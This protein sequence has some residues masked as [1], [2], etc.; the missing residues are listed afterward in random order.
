[1]RDLDV[2]A[3]K[4]HTCAEAYLPAH[5]KDIPSI[6]KGLVFSE[7]LLHSVAIDLLYDEATGHVTLLV[8]DTSSSAHEA[9]IQS[10]CAINMAAA[11]FGCSVF[12]AKPNSTEGPPCTI[13]TT[14][15]GIFQK[16]WAC[17]QQLIGG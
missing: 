6:R 12:I 8:Q 17:Q 9:C 10:W 1:M 3:D 7:S 5:L 14:L 4:Q 16:P 13:P 15:F 2:T 11:T